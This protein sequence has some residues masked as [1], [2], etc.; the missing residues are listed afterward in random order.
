MR[1]AKNEA[2]EPLPIHN[3]E[4][5]SDKG[6]CLL[7]RVCYEL[8]QKHDPFYMSSYKAANIV[9]KSQP[10]ALTILKMLVFEKVLEVVKKG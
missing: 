4:R 5:F 10:H 1:N 6:V 9:R 2:G 7:I 3:P 8:Q